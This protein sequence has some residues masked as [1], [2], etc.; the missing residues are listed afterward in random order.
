MIGAFAVAAALAVQVPTPEDLGELA[1]TLGACHG[2]G[3]TADR[4][5]A[6]A[7]A[8]SYSA[9]SGIA[10]A[11]YARRIMA[12]IEA[13]QADFVTRRDA[14]RSRADAMAFLSDVEQRCENLTE[15]YP[16]L[17]SQTPE[18]ERAW[19]SFQSDV[20]ASFPE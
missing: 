3:W 9:S 15:V 16:Q 14:M 6:Q 7:M 17:I 12:G 18:G 5:G 13:T 8:E 11:E 2:A 19:Q 1:F 20:V 10:D 4:A